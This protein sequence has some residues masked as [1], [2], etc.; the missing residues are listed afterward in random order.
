MAELA[1]ADNINDREAPLARL[2]SRIAWLVRLYGLSLLVGIIGSALI[3]PGLLAYQPA[4]AGLRLDPG[5]L[6]AGGRVAALAAL[7]VPALPLLWAVWQAL[8]LCRLMRH[9]AV[10]SAAVPVALR[11]L[12]IA[13]VVSA[14]L[15]PVGGALLSLAVSSFAG[16]GR[17]HVAIALSSDYV[18]VAVIGAILIVIAAAAREAVRLADE[19]SRFV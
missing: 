18:G 19:N 6:G 4:L 12:G 15:Q 2:G 13:L 8:A 14:L 1:S 7:A 11:R 9:G 5:M 3:W 10:F 17:R 16:D